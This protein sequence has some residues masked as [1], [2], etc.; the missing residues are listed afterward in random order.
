MKRAAE[1][2][3]AEQRPGDAADGDAGGHAR[4]PRRGSRRQRS[5]SAR[6][7][8]RPCSRRRRTGCRRGRSPARRALSNCRPCIALAHDRHQKCRG[9]DVAEAEQAIGDDQSGER[10][11]FGRQVRLGHRRRRQRTAPRSSKATAE[12]AGG[13]KCRRPQP[14]GRPVRADGDSTTIIGGRN[15]DADADAAEMQRLK[16]G[17]PR[18]REMAKTMLARNT[19]TK[20]L[21]RPARK[22]ITRKSVRLSVRPMAPA[23]SAL[24]PVRRA[25]AAARGPP[26]SRPRPSPRRSGNPDSW[27]RRSGRRRTADRPSSSIMPGRI[28]V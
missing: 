15:G 14:A 7:A 8:R 13:R 16:I 4:P 1:Q 27:P 10:R 22:R 20:A 21:A 3:A 6:C 28:G 9:D 18:G 25:S 11:D 19:M 5:W 17:A 23:S 26:P 12:Q 24:R 2:H